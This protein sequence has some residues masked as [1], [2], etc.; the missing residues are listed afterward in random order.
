MYYFSANLDNDT[1]LFLAPLSDR[2]LA[3]SGQE[4]E[5]ASGYFLYEVRG[6]GENAAV[7][8]I[9]QAVS[10]EAA[11]RLKDLFGMA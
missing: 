3:M 10:E 1:T 5:D 7:E 11:F 4:I 2:R 9:A 8:I 6:R